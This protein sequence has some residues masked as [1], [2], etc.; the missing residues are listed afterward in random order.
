MC[1]LGEADTWM[2]KGQPVLILGRWVSGARS[3]LP[4]SSGPPSSCRYSA[5]ELES[6]FG[7]ILNLV[8]LRGLSFL[9]H[10]LM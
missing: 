3:S 5:T 1:E 9:E 6:S 2:T 10:S 4:G 7:V 8:T